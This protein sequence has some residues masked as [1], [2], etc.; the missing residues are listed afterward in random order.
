DLAIIYPDDIA[1]DHNGVVHILWEWSLRA[2][3]GNRF[4]GSYISYEPWS[5]SFKTA[6]GK[7]VDIPV[8]FETENVIFGK[9]DSRALNSVHKMNLV[10]VAKLA[11]SQEGF[12]N[13]VFR[14]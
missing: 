6:A 5:D 8:S 4:R 14:A 12:P 11:V 10:Q 1:I 2:T 3:S 7:N 13:I 9:N